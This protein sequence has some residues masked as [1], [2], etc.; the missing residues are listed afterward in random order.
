NGLINQVSVHK[1]EAPE[2]LGSVDHR[3]DLVLVDG[4][5]L[6]GE[7]LL[8]LLRPSL[9]LTRVGG[10][11]VVAASHPAI[12][13]DRLSPLVAE[14]CEQ[15]RRTAVRLVQRSEPPGFPMLLSSSMGESLTAMA[16]EVH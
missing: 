8:R 4:R 15:E 13:P 9:R 11:L 3:F 2:V 10:R 5:E 16:L 12:A 6:E 14:A 1:G 7:A